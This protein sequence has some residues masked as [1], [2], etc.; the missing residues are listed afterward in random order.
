MAFSDLQFNLHL[1]SALGIP[2]HDIVK[3]WEHIHIPGSLLN[4]NR[5]LPAVKVIYA[6][7]IHCVLDRINLI[8]ITFANDNLNFSIRGFPCSI[9]TNKALRMHWLVVKVSVAVVVKSHAC[10]RSI[11]DL[12]GSNSIK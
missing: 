4:Y 9:K 6:R 3:A 5:P 10:R 1:R 12:T 11:D 7:S 2:Y 8:H